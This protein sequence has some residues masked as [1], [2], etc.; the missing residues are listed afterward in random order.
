M[1]RQEIRNKARKKLGE[2]TAAFWTDSEMNTWIDDACDDI[3][4]RTL[5][6]RSSTL[7]TPT[8]SLAEY[9]LTSQ[10][11]DVLAILDEQF[12]MDAANWDRLEPTTREELNRDYPGWKNADDGTPI[13]YYWDLEDNVHGLYPPPNST[14]AVTEYWQVFYAQRHTD[15]TGDTAAIDIP[16]ELHK[17]II[18]HVVATGLESRQSREAAAFHWTLY[19][20]YI[21]MWTARK[22]YN[23]YLDDDIIM[24]PGGR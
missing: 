18:E 13:M 21:N 16:L 24:V 15:I 12:Y 23:R 1:N 7:L 9:T 19:E 14:N 8:E 20:K 22:D 11:S 5:C 4:M 6:L 2:T 17:A 3:A 10:I